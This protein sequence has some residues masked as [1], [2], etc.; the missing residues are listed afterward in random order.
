M[1][2]DPLSIATNG[3]HTTLNLDKA[4]TIA[5]FGYGFLLPNLTNRSG[6]TD[7]Y[8]G[9]HPLVNPLGDFVGKEI[10]INLYI[11]DSKISQSITKT[12]KKISI[13]HIKV[14]ERVKTVVIKL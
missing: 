9:K 14:V 1:V 10:K 8:P 5:L 13:D 4:F 7:P 6:G 2:I 11:N 3:F 12:V